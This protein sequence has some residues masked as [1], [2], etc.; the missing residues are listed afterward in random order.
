VY[1]CPEK[2]KIADGTDSEG[3]AQV[4][5]SESDDSSYSQVE[6]ALK[7]TRPR[8]NSANQRVGQSVT[9]QMVQN[10]QSEIIDQETNGHGY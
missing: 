3:S 2:Q 10:M 7:P 4:Y 5:E 6:R 9:H 1:K 8:P